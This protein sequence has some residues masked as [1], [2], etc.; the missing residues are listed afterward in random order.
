MTGF[1]RAAGT[2]GAFAWTWEAKC[3]NG[4]GLEVRTRLPPG[5]DA[6]EPRLRALAAE[7]FRRGNLNVA[8]QL[9]R[10]GSAAEVR[11]NEEVLER[12]LALGRDLARRIGAAPPSVDGLL[13][14]RGVVDTVEPAEDEAERAA[15]EAA[16][17]D[18]LAAT[19]DRL[20]AARQE[21]GARLAVLL[22]EQCAR[23]R[24]LVAEAR[25]LAAVRPEAIRDRLAQQVA[26]LLEASAGVAPERLAQEVALLTVKADVREELD[27]LTAHLAQADDLL[28][29]GGAVGRRLDFLAQELNREANT[30]CSKSADVA[31]TRVGLEM[32]VTIDQFREQVQ[33]VE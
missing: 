16:L 2:H 27:R 12:L 1:A 3:V 19:L 18:G 21:E 33:N 24:A 30:L 26:E 32:K 17:L 29:A 22:S 14:L 7:R 5:H 9:V 23:L 15:R 10:T 31:L 4:R 13:A 11:V 25:G 6:L 20:A 28:S 8:L